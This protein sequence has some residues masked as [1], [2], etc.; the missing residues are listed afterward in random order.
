MAKQIQAVNGHVAVEGMWLEQ[1]EIVIA[2]Y[3]QT[4]KRETCVS[5]SRE[6]AI[7]LADAI[8]SLIRPQA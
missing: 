7:A 2:T 4:N 6:S 3:D 8:Q 5:F 1:E